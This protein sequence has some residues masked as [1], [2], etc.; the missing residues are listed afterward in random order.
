MNLNNRIKNVAMPLAKGITVSDV[1]IGL[2][3]TAVLLENGNAGVAYTFRDDA[4]GG[5]SAYQNIRPIAGRPAAQILDLFD[6]KDSIE[7]ALALATAN[8]LFNRRDKTYFKGDILE[9]LQIGP[10]DRVGMVGNFGPLIP[11]LR[12]QAKALYIFEQIDSPQGYLLPASQAEELLP[13]CQVALLTSTS[14]I[15]HTAGHLLELA[16]SCR[17]IVFLGAS[18]PLSPEVF[19]NTRVTMLSGVTV[20]NPREILQIVS[21]GGGMGFFKSSVNKVNLALSAP[22]P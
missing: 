11:S 18:T 7:S 13:R 8:A 22:S 9:Q 14:I 10:E 20:A 6:T 1:R 4:P 19:T 5:C 21:E 16:A 2:G 12:K 3:Y 15:N 17:D